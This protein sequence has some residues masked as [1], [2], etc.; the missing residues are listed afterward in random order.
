ME[1]DRARMKKPPLIVLITMALIVTACSPAATPTA[2]P[3]VSLGNNDT[4]NSTQSSDAN[5]VSASAVVVP[6]HDA[7]LAFTSMGRVTAVNVKVG[8]TVTAGQPLL[9][10][11]TALQEARVRE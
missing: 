1:N 8:D 4:A 5:S 6:A 3:T 10:L 9:T 7:R 2:I 11:D